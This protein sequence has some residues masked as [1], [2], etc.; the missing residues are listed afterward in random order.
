MGVMSASPRK[1]AFSRGRGDTL[2]LAGIGL[3]HG[4]LA[5]VAEIGGVSLQACRD[6]CLTLH[7]GADRLDVRFARLAKR[8]D[9]DDRHLTISRQ[10]LEMLVDAG[11][12]PAGAGLHVG[13]ELLDVRLA[14]LCYG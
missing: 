9:S 13:T 12:D 3:R 14:R 7:V 4:L 6:R 11:R 1:S 2:L 10:V 5:A 8:R